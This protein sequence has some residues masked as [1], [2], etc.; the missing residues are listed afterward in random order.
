MGLSLCDVRSCHVGVR[1]MDLRLL[2]M[3]FYLFEVGCCLFAMGLCLVSGNPAEHMP[4]IACES[5]GTPH[6]PT[7][8]DFML[9][10]YRSRPSGELLTEWL[11]TR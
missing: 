8:L 6:G 9:L 11:G 1:S 3:G 5:D 10:R 4:S 7:K 2:D